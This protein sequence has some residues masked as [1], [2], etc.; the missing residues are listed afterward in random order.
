MG[1]MSGVPGLSRLTRLADLYRMVSDSDLFDAKWYRTQ[2]GSAKFFPNP[3]IHYALVGWKKNLNPSPRFDTQFYW[4]S[5]RDVRQLGANPL[6]HFLL[7]GQKEG[8]LATTTGKAVRLAHISALHPLPLFEAPSANRQRLTVV[9]DDTTPQVT[10]LGF[11]PVMALAAAV[12]HSRDWMLRV[13]IRSTTITRQQVADSI[14]NGH[15]T[16]TVDVVMRT[17]GPTA[18]VECVAGEYFWATS[19]ASYLSLKDFVP[20]THL[21]WV[22]SAHE[23]LRHPVGDLRIATE[24]LMADDRVRSIV[25]DE[26]LEKAVNVAGPRV[27]ISSL[28]PLALV[29]PSPTTPPTIGVVV[30]EDS[31]D[32]LFGATLKL[33]EEALATQVITPHAH[34]IALI[35]SIERPITL[36][37]SVVPSLHRPTSPSQ[38]AEALRSCSV[39]VSLGAG[40]EPGYLAHQ[41]ASAGIAT[42]VSD[43]TT[44]ADHTLLD[45]LKAAL[46]GKPKK[47]PRQGW[48]EVVSSLDGLWGGAG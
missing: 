45:Q 23:S 32:N 36:T 21:H 18:D 29:R 9:I 7:H 2:G 38:W 27:T 46:S 1:P 41:A 3:V 4:D 43:V 34:Q 31:A 16:P 44:P 6:V 13:I 35:G 39:V 42:V 17:P 40:S 11:T 12:A 48:A 22:I 24:A 26:S 30:D 15:P 37:G 20:R 47:T 14:P 28:P 25:L 5:Y 33:I 8:R 10:G 19:A